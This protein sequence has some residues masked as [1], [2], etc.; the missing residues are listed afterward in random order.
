M[1]EILF[2]KI[3]NPFKASTGITEK[4]DQVYFTIEIV[5]YAENEEAYVSITG[6]HGPL[7]SGNAKGSCGQNI[8]DFIEDNS[9]KYNKHWN[10]ELYIEFIEFWKKNH[11]KPVT[12]DSTYFN[13]LINETEKFPKSKHLP[14]WH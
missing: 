2:E 5:K 8:D 13:Q 4:R 3:L 7:P 9:V 12:K 10:K 14:V 6:V 11:M 1:E